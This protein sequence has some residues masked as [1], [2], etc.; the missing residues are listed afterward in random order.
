MA[1][2]TKIVDYAAKDALNTG[3][4]VKLVKGTELGAEYDAIATAIATKANSA[5][6]V[7][8]GVSSFAVGAVGAPSI[9]MTGYATT[10]WYNI[11]ANNWGFAVSGAK[12]LDISSTGLAVTGEISATGALRLYGSAGGQ[13]TQNGG[14]GGLYFANTGVSTDQRFLTT[15]SAGAN[16]TNLTLLGGDTPSNAFSSNLAVTG[17]LSATGALTLSGTGQ[18]LIATAASAAD[19]YATISNTNGTLEYGVLAGGEGFIG[20]STADNLKL[21]VNDS[22]VGNISSTGLAVTGEIS[23]TGDVTASGGNLLLGSGGTIPLRISGATTGSSVARIQN[24]GGDAIFGQESSAGNA[25]I[26]GCSAYDTIIR[27]PS[28]LAFSAN[29]GSAMQMRL[30][31]TGLAVT[32]TLSATGNISAT[33]GDVLIRGATGG[34]ITQNTAAGG[35][36]FANTGIS[37]NMRF[38]TTDGAGASVLALTLN[39]TTGLGEFANGL[40][41]TGTIGASGTITST[42]SGSILQRTGASTNAQI[43]RLANT[44]G[45]FYFGIESSVAG[46]YFPS[47][48]AYASVL[49]STQPVQTIV[50]GVKITDTNAAGLAVTGTL[51][52]TGDYKIAGTGIYNAIAT[53]TS[54]GLFADANAYAGIKAYGS[55]H[56]TKA[57]VTEL[58]A[59]TGVVVGTVSSTG[60]AVTGTLSATGNISATAGDVLIRGAT[61]GLITQ[62]TAAGGLYF[63]NT[64]ISTNMRFYT[65]D[66]AGASVLALT[67]NNTTG[68]GEFANG[69]AVTGTLSA[70]GDVTASGGNVLGTREILQNSQ[71]AAYTTVLTDSGKH[72]LHPS[73]DTTAR[74]FTIDSNANVAYPVGTAITFVNQASAGVMT[75]S[76][77]SDTMR[78][79]GAGTTGS[80]TLAANGIATALKITT[81]E[82]IISGTGLT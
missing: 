72:I 51:S 3:D 47:S 16:Q 75:I 20:T 30:S 23:A 53:N 31:S 15:N 65:T 21:Q 32:G 2:Y 4:P 12:V 41:V 50:G 18:V 71:S 78:L 26:I 77:T 64:G 49:A 44:T 82:W 24:T 17:A 28:G 73:A 79:A 66:G 25:L 58:L 34:L 37:T 7:F 38:Y 22:V 9:Y 10:G 40:A 39:N 45:D 52:S 43:I 33:A 81:T 19:K 11:G 67:L 5:S 70:T 27:G 6:P 14:V 59:G 46:S 60:L 76:I 63:A 80:R 13:I 29:A 1:N 35:L 55:S 54:L 36:Y 42:A 68:L 61:G 62:N 48:S 8:T 56:A 74:T 57:N 69:L